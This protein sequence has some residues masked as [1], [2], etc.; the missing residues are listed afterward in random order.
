MRAGVTPR[1][2]KI[3]LFVH[4]TNLSNEAIVGNGVTSGPNGSQLVTYKPPRQW[5]SGLRFRF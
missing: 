5:L 4:G 3:E 2:G 1:S